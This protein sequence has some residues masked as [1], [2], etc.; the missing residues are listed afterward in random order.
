MGAKPKLP[1]PWRSSRTSWIPLARGMVD[2]KDIHVKEFWNYE[3]LTDYGASGLGT[4][5]TREKGERFKAA[6]VDHLV[7]FVERKEAQGWVIP[8]RPA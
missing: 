6:L 2:E 5:A 1:S 7:A 4:A 8:K 3:E